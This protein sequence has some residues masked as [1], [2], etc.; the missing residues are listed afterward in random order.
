MESYLSFFTTCTNASLDW[1]VITA[2][3]ITHSMD[4]FS[5]VLNN[6]FSCESPSFPPH[7]RALK[8][9]TALSVNWAGQDAQ[10]FPQLT[11]S[12][13]TGF[14]LGA[15]TINVSSSISLDFWGAFSSHWSHHSFIVCEPSYLNQH[16]VVSL[17]SSLLCCNKKCFGV[18]CSNMKSC[19]FHNTIPKVACNSA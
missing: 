13:W 7:K 4:A 14:L 1:G 5:P 3:T 9:C 19:L 8:T 17:L 11:S 6:H 10:L 15:L 12:D 16:N 2:V 18:T